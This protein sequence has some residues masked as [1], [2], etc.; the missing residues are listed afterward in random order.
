MVGGDA[1]YCPPQG[2]PGRDIRLIVEKYLKEHRDQLDKEAGALV[3]LSLHQAFR[4]KR[5]H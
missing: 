1:K 2:L 4:C 5:L 3:G